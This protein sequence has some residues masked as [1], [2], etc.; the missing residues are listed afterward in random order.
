MLDEVSA[1]IVFGSR[2]KGGQPDGQGP[3]QSVQHQ[4]GDAE[5][6][7][8]RPRDVCCANVA[9]SGLAYVFAAKNAHQQVPEGNRAQQVRD[10]G[11]D[12]INSCHQRCGYSSPNR[13]SFVYFEP[14]FC[15]WLWYRKNSR[16][17]IVPKCGGVSASNGCNS[18]RGRALVRASVRCGW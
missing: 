13:S 15:G 16:A 11:D 5:S 1:E 10:S 12:E 9:A 2:K 4:R 14:P 3:L 17:V 8:P 7:G 6:L 18:R